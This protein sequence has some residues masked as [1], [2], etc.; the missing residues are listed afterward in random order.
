MLRHTPMR[1][2]FLAHEAIFTIDVTRLKSGGGEQTRQP[3][4]P[5]GI[6]FNHLRPEAVIGVIYQTK[7]NDSMLMPRYL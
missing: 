2:T 6:V 7:I 3:H 5:N 1:K 4:P